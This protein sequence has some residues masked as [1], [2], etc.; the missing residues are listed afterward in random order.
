MAAL[1][2]TLAVH[3]AHTILEHAAEWTSS[4]DHFFDNI[5]TRQC[6]E[7]PLPCSTTSA[8]DCVTDDQ[9]TELYKAAAWEFNYRFVGTPLHNKVVRLGSG[10][11]IGQILENMLAGTS[12]DFDTNIAA[13]EIEEK[14]VIL[15]SGHGELLVNI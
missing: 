7:M 6:H 4:F 10:A 15:Y 9:A 3:G 11:L 8:T 13:P 12:E 2:N 1:S 14:R 5:Q